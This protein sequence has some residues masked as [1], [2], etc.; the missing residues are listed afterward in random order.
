MNMRDI[1]HGPRTLFTAAIPT[2]TK[3]LDGSW[4]VSSPEVRYNIFTSS[5]YR[6]ELITTLNQTQ[7]ATKGYMQSPNDWKNVEITAYLKLV[8][9]G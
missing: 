7:L 6:P 5:G 8:N 9:Q 1:I 3:N 2:L 4:K